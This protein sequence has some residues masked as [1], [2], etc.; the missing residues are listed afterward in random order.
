MFWR[1]IGGRD[2][3]GKGDVK[4][5]VVGLWISGGYAITGMDERPS[6]SVVLRSL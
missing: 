5:N 2:D 3:A 1:D 4:S 6:I